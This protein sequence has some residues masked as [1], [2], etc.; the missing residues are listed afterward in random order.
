MAL[1][2][3]GDRNLTNHTYDE[4]FAMELSTRMKDYEKLLRI[5][6][7]KIRFDKQ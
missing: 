6:L 3:S 5:W 7:E 2:M 4:K 1:R